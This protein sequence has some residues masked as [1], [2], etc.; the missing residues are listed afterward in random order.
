M[1]IKNNLISPNLDHV[2]DKGMLQKKRINKLTDHSIN[3]LNIKTNDAENLVLKLSGG[4]QQKIA[5][6][7]WLP[8]NPKLLIIDE[9][10]RGV[11]V[12]AK[13]EVYKILRQLAKDGTSIMLISSE[14]PEIIGLCDRAIIMQNGKIN[15][16]IE[17]KDFSEELILKYASGYVNLNKQKQNNIITHE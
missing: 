16:Q 9:P 13:Q 3:Q 4:N 2:T 10:T 5:L 12:G 11:D 8:K 14:L 15:G 17:K 1:S 7:K 6:G